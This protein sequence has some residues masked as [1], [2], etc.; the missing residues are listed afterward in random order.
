[1]SFELEPRKILGINYSLLIT[2]PKVWLDYHNLKKKDKVT[3]TMTDDDQGRYLI[4][5]P[6]KK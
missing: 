6:L 5:K 2:L 1:M 4:L 3:I